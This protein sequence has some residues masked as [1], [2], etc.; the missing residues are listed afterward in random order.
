MLNKRK[1]NNIFDYT[2]IYTFQLFL[3]FMSNFLFTGIYL[4]LFY[5]EC[6]NFYVLISKLASMKFLGIKFR[7][8]QNLQQT[9]LSSL[10]TKLTCLVAFIIISAEKCNTSKF[11][12]FKRC[13]VLMHFGTFWM[14]WVPKKCTQKSQHFFQARTLQK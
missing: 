9:L 14:V 6:Y 5:F 11:K 8:F 10:P 4:L 12:S 2:K 13:C 7:D 1:C 3:Y